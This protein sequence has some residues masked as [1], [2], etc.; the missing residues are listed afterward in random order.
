MRK[1]KLI[2]EGTYTDIAIAFYLAKKFV[3]KFEK[4]SAFELGII[5]KK[6]K[7]LKKRLSTKEERNAFTVLDKLILRIRTLVGDNLFVK[8]ASIGLLLADHKPKG[9]VIEEQYPDGTTALFRKVQE[10]I[11]E[12]KSQINI[13]LEKSSEEIRIDYETNE[14]KDKFNFLLGVF[15]DDDLVS[16]VGGNFLP[17]NDTNIQFLA[18]LNMIFIEL[19][20]GGNS[21]LS[22]EDD[23]LNT[24]KINVNYNSNEIKMQKIEDEAGSSILGD[25]F[26]I[27][28]TDDE[29]RNFKDGWNKFYSN[30]KRT[31]DA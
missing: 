15:L 22:I 20:I 8:I 7:I 28:N 14:L 10:Q 26:I 18:Q 5:D 19:D 30:M 25:F 24:I 3:T 9:K 29:M 13:P 17:N 27:F 16:G 23:Q 31:N 2:T 4:W 12:N 21:V 1:N 6:G 11:L